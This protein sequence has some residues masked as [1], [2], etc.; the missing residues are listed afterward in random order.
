MAKYYLTV[1]LETAPNDCG[2]LLYSIKRMQK[3]LV[4]TTRAIMASLE[5]IAT[6]MS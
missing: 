3:K 6:T 2:S 5:S 1:R 4:G